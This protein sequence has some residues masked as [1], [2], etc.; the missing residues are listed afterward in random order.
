LPLSQITNIFEIIAS[1]AT[2]IT[3]AYLAMQIRSNNSLHKAESRRT[4]MSQSANLAMTLGQSK[5]ASEVFYRGLTSYEQ[6]RPEE[7]LQFDFLLSVL[8]GQSELAFTDWRL[9]ISGEE[10]FKT[11]SNH[12]FNILKTTAGKRYWSKHGHGHTPEYYQYIIE[13]VYEGKHPYKKEF[14][15]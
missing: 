9:G 7:A 5:E 14:K 1:I 3:L 15:D 4:I 8:A 2:V 11:P 6:L 10:A 12:F 13:N